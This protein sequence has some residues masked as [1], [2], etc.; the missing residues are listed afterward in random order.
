ML[1]RIQGWIWIAGILFIVLLAGCAAR[2]AAPD[3][4][5]IDSE[6]AGS[7]ETGGTANGV[8]LLPPQTPPFDTAGWRT[9][10]SKRIVEWDEILSG[11]P[12]KD[13]IPSVDDPTFESVAAAREWL[14]DRDPVIYFAHNEDVRAYP[15]AILIWHEIVNDK[16]GGLPVAVTFCPLCNASIV[17]DATIG[18]EAHQFGTTGRLRNSD[19]V[20]YD[21]VTESWWQQFTGQALVG[22]YVGRQLDFL[23]S[24]VISFGD[25]AAAFPNGQVLQRPAIDRSYGANPYA[26]YDSTE[27]R[28]FL[29]TG[30]LDTRLPATE[31]VVGV[32]WDGNVMA[33]PFSAVADA[34][35]INDEWAGAAIVVM[36]KTGTASALDSRTISEGRDVGSVAVFKREV[37]GQTLTFSTNADGTFSDAETG[38]TWNILGKAVAGELE[39]GQLE[40]VLSFDHFW[41]AWAAFFPETSLYG[42]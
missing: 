12:P 28:P 37:D 11:G 16:V 19:L 24:Q 26:G 18:G 13:G 42:E 40:R 8:A 6:A 39:G 25:F 1:K 5:S 29:F 35:V 4:R 32:E 30:E 22:D 27:G 9:D 41:F 10:F 38:S 15:L 7:V 33:Y 17:F 14:T 2:L 3:T 23:P 31:R 36:H 21:R 34:G 20:M